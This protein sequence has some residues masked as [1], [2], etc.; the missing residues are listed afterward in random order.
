MVKKF[1]VKVGC[2]SR[3]F[4]LKVLCAFVMDMVIPALSSLKVCIVML[5]SVKYTQEFFFL[6]LCL[7]SQFYFH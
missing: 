6:S 5:S 1:S 3:G 7:L 2:R 4:E